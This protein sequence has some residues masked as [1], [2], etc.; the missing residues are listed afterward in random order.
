M[1][2]D[3]G[4]VDGP[5][6]GR[7]QTQQKGA[8]ERRLNTA[9]KKRIQGK[10]QPNNGQAGIKKNQSKPDEKNHT[11]DA[12]TTKGRAQGKWSRPLDANQGPGRARTKVE[13]RDRKHGQGQRRRGAAHRGPRAG[14][15]TQPAAGGAH[16]DAGSHKRRRTWRR[17]ASSKAAKRRRA[18]ARRLSAQN[19][20][21]KHPDY[22]PGTRLQ[23]KG[24][25]RRPAGAS[26]GAKTQITPRNA[27]SR[28]CHC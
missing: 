22:G 23:H 16:R 7:V 4:Q 21:E 27:A 18:R 12:G 15:T 20:R 26:A 28:R 25:K 14:V 6:N 5:P 9:G 2:R 3:G 11:R 1:Q 24:G 19:T 10:S 13:A 8:G 17:A